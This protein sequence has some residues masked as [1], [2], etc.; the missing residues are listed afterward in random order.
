MQVELILALTSLIAAFLAGLGVI[1]NNLRATKLALAASKR[2]DDLAESTAKRAAE[3]SE[4]TARKDELQLL[5]D[6]VYRLQTRIVAL[7]VENTD[8]RKRY[9]SLYEESLIYLHKIAILERVLIQHAIPLPKI[10]ER[11]SQHKG[12]NP[13]GE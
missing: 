7:E 12:K 9:D 1:L 4:T 10:P 3:L 13:K 2:A 6:E 11:T 5:R 8:W